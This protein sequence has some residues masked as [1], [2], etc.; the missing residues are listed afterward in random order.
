MNFLAFDLGASSGKLFL[1]Q[2]YQNK[3]NFQE[4]YRFE[5]KYYNMNNHLYWDFLNIFDNMNQG[6]REA[7]R[8]TKDNIDCFAVDGFS[9][10]FGFIS[11]SGELLSQIR[12]YR[13][14]RTTKAQDIIYN[15]ITKKQLYN[16]SGNQIAVFNSFMQLASMAEEGQDYMFHKAYKLLFIPDLLIYFLTGKAIAEYTLASV[17]QLYSFADR[18]WCQ[19]ILNTYHISKNLFGNLVNPGTLIGNTQSAYNKLIGTSGFSIAAVC[20]HDTASAFL[21]S[22]IRED[23][24][25][26]SCGTWALSGVE[27]NETVICEEGFKY[28]IAN[29]GGFPGSH[30]RLIRNVMGTWLIQESRR[31]YKEQGTDYSFSDIEQMVKLAAPFQFLIDVDDSQ[32]F[33]PDKMPEQICLCCQEYYGKIPMSPGE[34]FRCIYE[35]LAFKFRYS[36]EILE[37]ISAKPLNAVNILGGASK[38]GLL[39]QFTANACNRTV[40]AGPEEASALGN[41]AQQLL[42]AGLTSS[43]T[44]SKNI[45]SPCIKTS[46]Y[47]P[48]NTEIWDMH[49]HRFI[50]LYHLEKSC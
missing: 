41:T 19:E 39:C 29:E 5:N 10:D 15:K 23:C 8:I 1:A 34:V 4:I 49:Y 21:A 25:I 2:V 9:N 27:V 32:F 42:A 3:I 16:L 37:K 20:E 35:S 12:C 14:S 38:A 28:N 44:E 24:A 45:L 31:Y 40:T 26:I 22:P 11:K 30:H 13:D 46:E 7:V 47:K 6:I 17:S 43:L 50:E 36:V 48:R 33:S 18:D